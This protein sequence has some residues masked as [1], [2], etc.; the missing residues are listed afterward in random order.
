METVSAAELA[1]NTDEILDRVAVGEIIAI[2]RNHTL[3]ALIVPCEPR[4]TAVQALAGLRPM[5]AVGQG[6]AWL[7]QSKEE[8][9]DTVRDPWAGHGDP[10]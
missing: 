6:A 10:A 2:K 3:I 7:N 4:M 5:L 9:E 8:F 1:R